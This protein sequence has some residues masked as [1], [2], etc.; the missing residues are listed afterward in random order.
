MALVK[1]LLFYSFLC[2]QPLIEDLLPHLDPNKYSTVY[3]H[4]INL[5][6]QTSIRKFAELPP[7]KLAVVRDLVEEVASSLDER[8]EGGGSQ[9]L[10][11]EGEP[12]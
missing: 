6:F 2:S 1:K 11:E 10:E 8:I 12:T 5:F 4:V 9:V 7:P 3:N